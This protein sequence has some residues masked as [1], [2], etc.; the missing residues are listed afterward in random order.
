MS[1]TLLPLFAPSEFP[2]GRNMADAQTLAM[3]VPVLLVASVAKQLKA[4]MAKV[5]ECFAGV[6]HDQ[7]ELNDQ[8]KQLY[9]RRLLRGMVGVADQAK[10]VCKLT[11]AWAEKFDIQLADTE[12]HREHE[13]GVSAAG[14]MI[15][16]TKGWYWSILEGF[17]KLLNS[18]HNICWARAQ[19]NYGLGAMLKQ[20][21]NG[22]LRQRKSEGKCI[23]I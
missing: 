17:R 15:L 22:T 10:L 18:L 23:F 9:V 1:G 7:R 21:L 16:A 5:R 20:L 11:L 2:Y 14:R 3:I 13:V 6:I 12:K 19:D 8:E 4:P